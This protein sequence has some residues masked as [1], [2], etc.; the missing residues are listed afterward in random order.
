M[1]VAK[2]ADWLKELYW[3]D[4]D[5]LPAVKLTSSDLDRACLEDAAKEL[6]AKDDP[7]EDED[8]QA[9]IQKLLERYQTALERLWELTS[10]SPGFSG[11]VSWSPTGRRRKRRTRAA[12]VHR[13]GWSI[14]SVI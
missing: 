11:V 4:D 3:V 7:I 14:L 10:C 1:R 12:I 2:M 6:T 13:K 9:R 8:G 5:D